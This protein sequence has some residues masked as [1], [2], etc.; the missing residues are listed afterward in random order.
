[1]PSIKAEAL[2]YD[3]IRA[4]LDG[5]KTAI[6]RP[7]KFSGHK[8]SDLLS[9]KPTRSASYAFSAYNCR[10]GQKVGV[11]LKPRHRFGGIIYVRE[12]YAEV[13]SL[14]GV[15]DTDGLVFMSDFSPADL[16]EL[17]EKGFR[18]KP[19]ILM[20]KEYA[21]IFLRVKRVWPEHLNDISEN[22]AIREGIYKYQSRMDGKEE[23]YTFNSSENNFYP[24]AVNAFSEFWDSTILSPDLPIFGWSANPMVW[25][26]EFEVISKEEALGERRTVIHG[27]DRP[28]EAD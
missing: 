6:R 20:P 3:V 23:K 18:W 26:Y 19:P 7:V 9:S 10:T 14:S 8:V 21:R 15:C 13:S 5:H 25:A 1:M 24:S 4:I 28:D 17:K 11:F 12:S 2:T 22:C 27:K 16:R